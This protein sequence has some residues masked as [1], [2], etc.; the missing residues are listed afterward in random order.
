M[1]L[2]ELIAKLKELGVPAKD[3][4]DALK[5]EAQPFFQ[6]VFNRGHAVAT[7]QEATAKE[8]LNAQLQAAQQAV[9]AKDAEIAE[10]KKKSPDVAAIREQYEQRITELQTQLEETSTQA[11][12]RI[13]DMIHGRALADL[14]ALATGMGVDKDYADVLIH[15]HKIAER[16]KV[17]D[18]DGFDVLEEGKQIP[19]Q[20]DKPLEALAAW[21]YEQT[22]VALRT[23]NGDRGAGTQAGGGA[24]GGTFFDGIREGAKKTQEAQQ[25]KSAAERLPTL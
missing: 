12:A 9:Q 11:R 15:R 8:Q 7:A 4:A 24:P 5:T 23:S 25:V 16:I 3:F 1:T 20:A 10:L 19:M 14:R 6:E 18:D 2:Q 21:M 17:R 13:V 22:P